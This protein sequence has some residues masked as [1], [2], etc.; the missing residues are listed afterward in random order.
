MT[1]SMLSWN[2]KVGLKVSKLTNAPIEAPNGIA[3]ADQNM[4]DIFAESLDFKS[5]MM[6]LW[7][8][9]IKRVQVDY[10]L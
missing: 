6:T 1:I 10:Y 2:C 8:E 9:T 4:T 3:F 5:Y 7:T